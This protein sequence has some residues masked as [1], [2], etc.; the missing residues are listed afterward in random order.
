MRELLVG[1]L[2]ATSVVMRLIMGYG[3]VG[4]EWADDGAALV[5]SQCET[6]H[7]AAL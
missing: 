6:G 1:R 4:F 7:V 5:V 2:G 3:Q